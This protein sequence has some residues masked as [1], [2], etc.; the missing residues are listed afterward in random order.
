MRAIIH[1]SDNSQHRLNACPTAVSL[2]ATG[3]GVPRLHHHVL[4]HLLSD[5]VAE[6][7]RLFSFDILDPRFED[8][9][10]QAHASFTSAEGMLHRI[11]HLVMRGVEDVFHLGAVLESLVYVGLICHI[12]LS[13]VPLG[14]TAV[15]LFGPILIIVNQALYF[16]KFALLSVVIGLRLLMSSRVQSEGLQSLQHRLTTCHFLSRVETRCLN[17]CGSGCR[18]VPSCGDHWR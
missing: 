15:S 10:A 4:T 6:A 1:D 16:R 18:V 13:G 17:W 9:G 11:Q 5:T 2:A 14:K 8:L 7:H 3:P 12:C